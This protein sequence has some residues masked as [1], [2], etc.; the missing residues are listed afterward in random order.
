MD[1]FN[2]GF[3]I[4]GVAALLPTWIASWLEPRPVAD[5]DD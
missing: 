3:G 1:W 5:F 4:Q 2:L